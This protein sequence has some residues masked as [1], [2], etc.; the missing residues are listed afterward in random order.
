MRIRPATREDAAAL[1]AI[2]GHHVANGFGSFEEAAPSV[3]TMTERWAA[4][5]ARAYPPILA[6]GGL[7][8]PRVTWWE[9]QKW[10]AKLRDHST[11]PAPMLLQMNLDAGHGGAPGRFDHLREVALDYAFAIW[12]IEGE[13]AL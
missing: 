12:A 11:G 5:A 8:D 4:I 10:I 2:Y 13:G 3:E 7:T 6:R 1:Q 9:P